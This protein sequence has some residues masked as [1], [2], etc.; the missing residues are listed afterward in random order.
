MNG[1]LKCL[2][3]YECSKLR[4]ITNRGRKTQGAFGNKD[5]RGESQFLI[6]QKEVMVSHSSILLKLYFLV[7]AMGGSSMEALS[8]S[9][10][11]IK[12]MFID[13]TYASTIH[14][15]EGITLLP[16]PYNRDQDSLASISARSLRSIQKAYW[17]TRLFLG[18]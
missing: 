10:E 4:Q 17:K 7:L 3:N 12:I 18:R 8:Q 9:D 14:T 15:T 5:K 13:S 2:K 6:P 11:V 16:F 1:I